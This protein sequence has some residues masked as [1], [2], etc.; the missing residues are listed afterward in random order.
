MILRYEATGGN[1]NSLGNIIGYKLKRAHH[2][3]SHRMDEA[4][5][6]LGITTGSTRR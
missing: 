2:S 4:L 5:K 3:L 6:T 1:N